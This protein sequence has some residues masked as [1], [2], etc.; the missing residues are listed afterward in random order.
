M[1][2]TA[3]E[4]V[5]YLK[6]I[7]IKCKTLGSPQAT[8]SRVVD[9]DDAELGTLSWIRGGTATGRW[10]GTIMLAPAVG[11]WPIDNKSQAVIFCDNP[12][13]AFMKVVPKFFEQQIRQTYV[14]IVGDGADVHHTAVI[15]AEGQGYEWDIHEGKHVSMPHLAGVVIGPDVTIGPHC[16]VMRGVLRDTHIGKGTKIGNGVNVGHGVL[17]GEHCIIVAHATIGGSVR[18]GNHVTIWQGAMIANGVHIGSDAV[19]GMGAV[20][21]ESVPNSETHVGNPA[22]KLR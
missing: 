10:Y 16:T 20:V 1:S 2:T 5:E 4:I 11:S 8:A 13:L 18:I 21:L 3:G 17:I 19:I 14:P 6:G 7:G 15:G 9:I 12:R 22:H